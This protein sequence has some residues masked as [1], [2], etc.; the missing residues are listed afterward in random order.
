[1]KNNPS[2]KDHGSQYTALSE[3][4]LKNRGYCCQSN[5]ENCPYTEIT[6]DAFTPREFEPQSETQEKKILYQY[7]HYIE[8]D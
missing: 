3:D 5:C 8:K 2:V 6:P 4:F 1:M 7:A